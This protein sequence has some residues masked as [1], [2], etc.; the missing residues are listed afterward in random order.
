MPPSVEIQMQIYL[1]GLN[2]VMAQMVFDIRDGMPAI[3][4]I[5]RPAV[6]EAVDGIDT[7]QAFGWKGF[8]EVFFADAVDPVASDFLSPLVDKDPVL[9]W[10]PWRDAVFVDIELEKMTGFGLERYEPE[11]I[12]LPQDRQCHFFGVEVVQFQGCHFAGPCAGIVQQVQQGIIPEA[13]F[14]FQINRLKDLQDLILIKIADQGFMRPFLRDIEDDI[15]RLLLFRVQE[16]DHFG[17]GFEGRK[18][19]IAG[20]G[21]VFSFILKVCK[22]CN[23][24]AR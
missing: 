13:L 17:E 2:R 7:L 18:P 19:L 10:R 24:K 23:D 8:F 14:R 1:G 16:S 12:S 5:Y 4:H 15:C 9:I 20:P 21:Q 3:E 11:P 22:E 6:A